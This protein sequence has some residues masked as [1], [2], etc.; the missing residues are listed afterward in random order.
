MSSPSTRSTPGQASGD[1]GDDDAVAIL[2]QVQDE[3]A[4]DLKENINTVLGGDYFCGP[5]FNRSDPEVCPDFEFQ[6]TRAVPTS[7][8]VRASFAENAASRQAIVTAE[9]NASAA[10]AEAE[11]QR[12]AQRR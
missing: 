6:I 3:I 11:G 8:A 4:A 9:N 12:R 7:E 10:V 5:T 2:E 1:A